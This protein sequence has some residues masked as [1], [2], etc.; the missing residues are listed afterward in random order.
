MPRPGSSASRKVRWPAAAAATSCAWC[1]I[2]SRSPGTRRAAGAG[3]AMHAGAPLPARSNELS[4]GLSSS[5]PA[6]RRGRGV[7]GRA[8][9]K[10]GARNGL[11]SCRETTD[12]GTTRR[13]VG[14]GRGAPSAAASSAAGLDARR[15]QHVPLERPGRVG[16]DG[17]LGE[18]REERGVTHGG[19]REDRRDPVQA[20]ELLGPVGRG[21]RSPPRGPG[22]APRAQAVR[23]PG[24]SC[25]RGRGPAATL[26]AASTSRTARASTEMTSSR[27][28]PCRCS[29]GRYG[30]PRSGAGLVEPQTPP[31]GHPTRTPRKP[32]RRHC[33]GR[34]MS[35]AG[36]PELAHPTHDPSSRNWGPAPQGQPSHRT[37]KQAPPPTAYGAPSRDERRAPRADPL[38]IAI[39]GRARRRPCPPR[40]G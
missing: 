21:S 31:L 35:V 1:G 36:R 7:L 32:Y 12:C 13:A 28:R 6:R 14:G 29:A 34:A 37:S 17:V 23:R 27:S 22:R 2:S 39:P 24:T 11:A 19:L 26:D 10:S 20:L 16:D 8:A 33:R 15:P 4:S 25:A 3:R 40:A 38:I 30:E 5:Q 9:E 18:E